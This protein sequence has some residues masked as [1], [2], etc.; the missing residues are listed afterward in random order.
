MQQRLF[1][2]EKLLLSYGE[3]EEEKNRV[4]FFIVLTAFA[5][6]VKERRRTEER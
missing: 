6:K 4:F 1:L 5:P 2:S 3:F